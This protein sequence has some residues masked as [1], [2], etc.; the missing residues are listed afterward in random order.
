[1]LGDRLRISPMD[2]T[3]RNSAGN[4]AHQICEVDSKHPGG[5]PNPET[6]PWIMTAFSVVQWKFRTF[7]FDQDFGLSR[8]LIHCSASKFIKCGCASPSNKNNDFTDL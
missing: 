8:A 2:T 3:E 1:M 4:L 5:T 7:S 6:Y